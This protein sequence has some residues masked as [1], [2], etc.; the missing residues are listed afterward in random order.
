[1]LQEGWVCGKCGA[2]N[3]P[4]LLQCPCTS[5]ATR[6]HPAAAL[7]AAPKQLGATPV[8]QP[9]AGSDGS[10]ATATTRKQH[11]YNDPNFNS[12]WNNYPLHKGKLDA[13]KAFAAA[14]AAGADP[15]QL[16]A[17]AGAYALDASRNPLKT[18]MAEGWLRSKRWEDEPVQLR[19]PLAAV[20][21]TDPAQVVG[22]PEYKARQE[23]E[24][25]AAAEA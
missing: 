14:V 9:V 7:A 16:I 13:A 11:S 18:K 12:F 1:M 5:P 4:H 15:E 6:K 24:W 10:K 21:E 3:A 20:D 17:A 19:H 8:Q 2:S 25:K 23:A 22:T